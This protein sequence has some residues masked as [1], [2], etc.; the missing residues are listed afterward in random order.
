MCPPRH[1]A[2]LYEINPWMHQEVAVDPDL[3]RSQWEALV[4]T[5]E[6]AGARI[7]RL[8]PHPELPDL[9]FTANAGTVNGRRFVPSRFRHPQR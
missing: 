1:F 9:V 8:D 6:G 3:A 4:T 5:L 7:E 2:V